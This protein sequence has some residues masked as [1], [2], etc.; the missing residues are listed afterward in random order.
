MELRVNLKEVENF[1]ENDKFTKF[2]IDNNTDIN[3]PAFILSALYEKIEELKG[4]EA[5]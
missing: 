4:K 3:V 1:I 5:E 2:L